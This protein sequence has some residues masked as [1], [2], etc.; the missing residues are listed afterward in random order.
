MQRL[1]RGMRLVAYFHLQLVLCE[2]QLLLLKVQFQVSV[3]D[4]DFWHFSRM[5]RWAGANAFGSLDVNVVQELA[6]KVVLVIL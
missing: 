3:L 6:L 4:D 2:V 1:E 5:H